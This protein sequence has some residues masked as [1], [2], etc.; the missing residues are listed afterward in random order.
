LYTKKEQEPIRWDFWK[1]WRDWM[2]EGLLR[3]DED[4]DIDPHQF[5]KSVAEEEDRERAVT[6]GAAPTRK[7]H[8]M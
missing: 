3:D 1:N 5:A 7:A 2:P 4:D 6:K 8:L